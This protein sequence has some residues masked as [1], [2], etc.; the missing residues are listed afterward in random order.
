MLL[1]SRA[2]RARTEMQNS[3]SSVLSKTDSSSDLH[4]VATFVFPLEVGMQSCAACPCRSQGG[5]WTLLQSYSSLN[6][7]LIHAL[8]KWK[9][10]NYGLVATPG[11]RKASARF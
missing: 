2:V 1:P 3:S 5:V 11:V 6:N 9:G 7:W 8:N 10:A 4:S